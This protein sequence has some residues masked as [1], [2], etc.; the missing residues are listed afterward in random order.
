M[1]QDV[2][3]LDSSKQTNEPPKIK[4]KP[5]LLFVNKDVVIIPKKFRARA[6]DMSREEAADLFHIARHIGDTLEKHFGTT[7][8][9]FGIQDGPEA[10]QS[11]EVISKK[12]SNWLISHT[13]V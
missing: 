4:L 12:N 7:S 11:V 3:V 6:A 2:S 13:I 9:N 1:Y 5:I 10:G 8:I